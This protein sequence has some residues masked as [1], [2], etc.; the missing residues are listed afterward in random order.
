MNETQQ[1]RPVEGA[2]CRRLADAPG[3]ATS[4]NTNQRRLYA[5]VLQEVHADA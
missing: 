2:A 3:V 4:C 1:G 5:S